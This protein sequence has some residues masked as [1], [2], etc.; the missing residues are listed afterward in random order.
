MS[1][2]DNNDAHWAH[3]QELELRHREEELLLMADPGYVEFLREYEASHHQHH[4]G[5]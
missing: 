1:A 2:E 5:I 3:E 4:V